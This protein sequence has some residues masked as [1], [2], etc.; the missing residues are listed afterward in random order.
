MT[1]V[2]STDYDGPLLSVRNVVQ[3]Y[4]SQG[5]G[6]V[7]AGVVHAV[8]DVSFDLAVGQT[9]GIVGETG[10]GKSTLARATIQ[11]EKPKSGEVWFK[12]QN[13][14]GMSK[15]ELKRARRDIQ[16]V[17][18]DPFGSLNPRWRV[19][20]VVA[21]PLIGHTTMGAVERRARVRELLELVGL[22]PDIYLR[23]RP[24]ELSGG[25]AQRVAIAR[26]IATNPALVVCDE[27]ISSLDVL[28]Q[29]QIMNLFEKLRAELGLSYVFIAHDLA[30]VK[31]L[32][33]QVA[34][35]HLGQLAEVGP[36]E[37]VYG[38]PRHPYTSALLGS[39]PGLDP[40]TGIA[41]RP[42]TLKGEPPSPLHPPSGCRFRTRCPRAQEKCAVEE[43]KL[44]DFGAGH[45]AACHFPLDAVPTVSVDALRA[46][47]PE[48]ALASSAVASRN[49]A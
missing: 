37:L 45:K 7:K 43:P 30:T 27:A 20:D 47:M 44:V 48:P 23:R 11:V 38:S 42:V 39:I 28:I 35:M 14:V 33:D 18:Q 34:V 15:R 5:P 19:E 22:S 40:V 2:S 26:A 25:Q 24:L 32:S 3:E 41:R 10:S 49:R 46:T 4:V 21:E 17:Y 6:G 36:A 9:L 31:Q 8:S 29:A 13:L 16:M 12:G 1:T